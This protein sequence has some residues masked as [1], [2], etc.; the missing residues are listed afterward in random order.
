MIWLNINI[1]TLITSIITE[2]FSIIACDTL[3]TRP[4]DKDKVFRSK[5]LHGNSYSIACSGSLDNLDKLLKD[6]ESIKNISIEYERLLKE[7]KV[8]YLLDQVE[9]FIISHKDYSVCE[10]PA[11]LKSSISKFDATAIVNGFS[12]D[13]FY[14]FE[15]NLSDLTHPIRHAFYFTPQK[16][17]EFT[18]QIEELFRA[19]KFDILEE[20]SSIKKVDLYKL[21]IEKLYEEIINSE[22]F[23][24]IGGKLEYRVYYKNGRSETFN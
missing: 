2:G 18:C 7:L 4:S 17:A 24:T 11:K 1:M 16:N 22:E 10:I 9:D 3:L 5:L 6:I 12:E 15:I 14:S 20:Q 13:Q 21:T 8:S 23:D 19:I